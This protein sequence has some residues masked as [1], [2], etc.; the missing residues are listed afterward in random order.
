MTIHLPVFFFFADNTVILMGSCAQ[1]VAFI[2]RLMPES[3]VL[4]RRVMFV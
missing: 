2:I 3:S 4:E 1:A